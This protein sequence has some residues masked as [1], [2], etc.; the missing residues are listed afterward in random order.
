MVF[1][2]VPKPTPQN[3]DGPYAMSVGSPGAEVAESER[4]AT[5]LFKKASDETL[6]SI[7]RSGMFGWISVG[8]L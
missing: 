1:T 2:D 8:L 4:L 7:V 5:S 6:Y 3:K